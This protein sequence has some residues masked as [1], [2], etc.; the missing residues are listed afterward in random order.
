MVAASPAS[1]PVSEACRCQ[2]LQLKMM[3]RQRRELSIGVWGKGRM[4]K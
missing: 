1:V 4:E 2:K 3:E